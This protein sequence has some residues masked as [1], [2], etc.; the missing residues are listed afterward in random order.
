MVS[1]K[2]PSAVMPLVFGAPLKDVELV[3]VKLYLVVFVPS[4]HWN[5]KL[6]SGMA[7]VVGVVMAVYWA[8]VG[9]GTSA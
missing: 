7:K 4:P 5:K 9:G 6:E 2:V 8:G 1:W 3:S